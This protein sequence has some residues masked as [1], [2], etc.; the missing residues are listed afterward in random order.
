M[1]VALL[2]TVFSVALIAAFI[3]VMVGGSSL[4]IVP[5]LASLGVPIFTAIG[6]NRIYVT[7]FV[8]TGLLNYLRKE[9]QLNLKFLVFFAAAQ[10]TG[11]AAGSFYVLNMSP[12]GAKKVVSTLMVLM[13]G[14]IFLLKHSKG[15]KAGRTNQFSLALAAT[16]AMGVY[17]GMVGGGSGIF[18]RAILTVLLGWTILE[19][20]AATL[21]MS[22]PASSVSSA[23]F[24]AKGTIDYILLLPMLAGGIIGAYAGTHLAVRKGTKWME[25]LFYVAVAALLI[26]LIFF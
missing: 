5:A 3:D 22:F 26:K 2:L 20:A 7:V 16:F 11:A 17:E 19:A 10:I 14:A 4:I 13:L 21:A 15:I 18:T 24:I 25:H 6:T 12:E 23:I 8:L 1:D 9:V